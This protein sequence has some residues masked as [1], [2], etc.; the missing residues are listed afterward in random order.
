MVSCQTMDAR[1]LFGTGIVHM[2]GLTM[3]WAIPFGFTQCLCR[4]PD[5]QPAAVYS[6]PATA[7][8][9]IDRAPSSGRSVG[10]MTFR[11]SFPRND[12]GG[13]PSNAAMI[14]APV[15]P[16]SLL[17]PQRDNIPATI[18]PICV[19]IDAGGRVVRAVPLRRAGTTIGPT[20]VALAA[21]RAARFE[22]GKPGRIALIP[23]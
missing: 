5:L 15:M 4:L 10:D 19:D 23:Q 1:A 17:L 8:M 18:S 2:T 9:V 13:D 20:G 7:T 12:C 21:A 11:L 3:A 22:P 16:R 6:V 14:D